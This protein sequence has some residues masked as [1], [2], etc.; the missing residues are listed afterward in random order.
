MQRFIAIDDIHSNDDYENGSRTS[1]AGDKKYELF[2]YSIEQ[3][4]VCSSQDDCMQCSFILYVV[5]RIIMVISSVQVFK[6]WTRDSLSWSCHFFLYTK[7]LQSQDFSHLQ[8]HGF[9]Q[10]CFFAFIISFKNTLL[11]KKSQLIKCQ[12]TLDKLRN[13]DTIVRRFLQCWSA[14]YE[15]KLLYRLWV[16]TLYCNVY[17]DCTVVP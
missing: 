13:R 14:S 4:H 16:I 17:V 12:S 3:L 8:L 7:Q 15:K 10:I 9:S 11:T 6:L 1:N 5:W 2:L